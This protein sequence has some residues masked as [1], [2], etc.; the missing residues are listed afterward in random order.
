MSRRIFSFY[1]LL[2][3]PLML[4]QHGNEK[5]G[6]TVLLILYSYTNCFRFLQFNEI[7]IFP[8]YYFI[9]QIASYIMG[10]R[11]ECGEGKG[12]LFKVLIIFPLFIYLISSNYLLDQNE[13]HDLIYM[14]MHTSMII[15]LHMSIIYS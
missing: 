15:G 1:L 3:H 6:V 4:Y 5:V 11:V 10:E 8:P 2:S 12:C 13:K 9:I 14:C 7:F